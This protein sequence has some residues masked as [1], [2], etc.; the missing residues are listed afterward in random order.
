MP[1]QE[2]R[3]EVKRTNAFVFERERQEREKKMKHQADAD[4]DAIL[5]YVASDPERLRKT[6]QWMETM[7][8]EEIIQTAHCMK[9]LANSPHPLKGFHDR[10]NFAQ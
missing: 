1:R 5:K 10:Q 9:R 7:S 8:D 2:Y 3:E 4:A 6:V